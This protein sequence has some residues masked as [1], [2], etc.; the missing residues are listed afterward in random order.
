MLDGMIEKVLF[1]NVPVAGEVLRVIVAFIGVL[2]ASY[3][4][5]FNKKNVPDKI[6]YSFLGIAILL[7]IVFYLM[8][9]DFDVLLFTFGAALFISVIG[10]IFYRFGQIGGADV[11]VITSVML[12]IPFVPSF[13]GLS[14]NLPFIIPA[15][16]YG[17]LLLTVYVT[18]KFALKIISQGGTPNLLY[19]LL[20]LPFLF[21]IY[22]YIN[23]PVFSLTYL[24]IISVLLLASIF[25]MVYKQ[26]IILM[27]AEQLPLE[28]VE[29]EDVFALELIEPAIIKQYNIKRLATV[30]EIQ[31]LKEAGLQTIWVYTDLPPFIPFLLVGMVLALFFSKNL[32][33]GF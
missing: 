12:L 17:G 15:M 13:A 3:Y 18:I 22:V 16:I 2:V 28:K 26:D 32:L 6:L 8:Q 4:D 1:T 9:P 24:F 29:P 27:L 20:L 5:L 7:N 11:I 21:F 23:S 31:R 19:L 10:Y 25:F 30:S 14:F 33:F